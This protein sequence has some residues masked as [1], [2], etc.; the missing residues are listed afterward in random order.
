MKK[1]FFALFACITLL[2]TSCTKNQ[3]REQKFDIFTD[4]KMGTS[5]SFVE[6]QL[7]VYGC[8]LIN[9]DVT[10]DAEVDAANANRV[11]CVE[12]FYDNAWIV[13]FYFIEDKLSEIGMGLLQ[14]TKT[15]NKEKKADEVYSNLKKLIQQYKDEEKLKITYDTKESTETDEFGRKVTE[16][17]YMSENNFIN[18]TKV[19]R[20]VYISIYDGSILL[21]DE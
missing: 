4:I 8:D 10:G 12:Y 18:I 9:P 7:R 1:V 15:K 20:Q 17:Q 3:A 6:R 2:L 13:N 16:K 21:G 19:D 11:G 14:E 5:R